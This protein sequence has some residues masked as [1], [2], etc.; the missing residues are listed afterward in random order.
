M[1]SATIFAVSAALQFIASAIVLRN[2]LAWRLER[3]PIRIFQN[4]HAQCLRRRSM[5]G[6][7]SVLKSLA[8]YRGA[9]VRWPGSTHPKTHCVEGSHGP[10]RFTAAVDAR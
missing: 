8:T 5:R 7:G 2:L 4:P 1:H 9:T 6:S 3:S 10:P